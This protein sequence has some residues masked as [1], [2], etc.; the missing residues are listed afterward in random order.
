MKRLIIEKATNPMLDGLT[1][2]S[3]TNFFSFGENDRCLAVTTVIHKPS[4]LDVPSNLAMYGI[5]EYEDVK[6]GEYLFMASTQVSIEADV[7]AYVADF[8]SEL[9]VL[10][11]EKNVHRVYFCVDAESLFVDLYCDQGFV[12]TPHDMVY[13]EVTYVLLKF[14]V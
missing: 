4:A 10:C 6:R 12:H 9:R 14:E 11:H 8:V 1:Y 7:D 5:E 2:S 3:I 13:D